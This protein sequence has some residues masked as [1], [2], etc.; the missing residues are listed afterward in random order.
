MQNISYSYK[1]T[2][3]LE[4]YFSR[5]LLIDNTLTEPFCI[6]C[7]WT[8]N[9][10]HSILLRK[11]VVIHLKQQYSTFFFSLAGTK[12]M[13]TILGDKCELGSLRNIPPHRGHPLPLEP[14]SHVLIIG[15][16]RPNQ[17]NAHQLCCNAL[18]T[19][20]VFLFLLN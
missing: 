16:H 17:P 1:R 12:R 3:Q 8:T 18:E 6:P 7:K 19:V 14:V 15:R 4:T 2:P 5:L 10:T 9:A 11:N 20:H 13:F